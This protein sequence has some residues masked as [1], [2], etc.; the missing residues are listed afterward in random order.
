MARLRR[1]CATGELTCER[2]SDGWG[3]FEHD[4]PRVML[5]AS[6]QER[7]GARRRAIALAV[8]KSSPALDLAGVVER[9]LVL[10]PG[11]VS[12]TTVAIDGEDHLVAVWP[13]VHQAPPDALASLAA[14][15]GGELLGDGIEPD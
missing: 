12:S 6:Q 11:T 8:P 9:H 1:W 4:L 10:P 14:M 13:S 5:M 15:V 2:D 7:I 3:L